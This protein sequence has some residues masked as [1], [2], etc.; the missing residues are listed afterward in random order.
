[1]EPRDPFSPQDHEE[2]RNMRRQGQGGNP[3]YIGG[4]LITILLIILILLLIF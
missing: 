2:I 3:M 4:G 1:M